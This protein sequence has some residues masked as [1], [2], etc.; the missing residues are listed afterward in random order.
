MGEEGKSYTVRNAENTEGGISQCITYRLLIQYDWDRLTKLLCK[1][2]STQIG[3]HKGSV[4]FGKTRKLDLLHNMKSWSYPF[5]LQRHNDTSY[6]QLTQHSDYQIF[7]HFSS[8]MIMNSFVSNI[9]L[10]VCVLYIK[11]TRL[12]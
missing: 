5:Y 6:V 3:R 4:Y 8:L 7:V 12:P 2:I 11:H 1:L 9:S 10:S